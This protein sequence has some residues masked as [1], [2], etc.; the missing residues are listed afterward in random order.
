MRTPSLLVLALAVGCSG[1]YSTWDLAPK[2]VDK[3]QSFRAPEKIA[4]T[5]KDGESVTFDQ[6]TQLVTEDGNGYRFASIDHADGHGEL[7]GETPEGN[8][9]DLDLSASA[10]VRAKHFS[11]GHTVVASVAVSVGLAAVAGIVVGVVGF[12][13]SM[14]AMSEFSGGFGG[15]FGAFG[16]G[17]IIGGPMRDPTRSLRSR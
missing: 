10:G 15:G 8:H 11:V 5:T 16:C 12:E 4:L 9:I 1:C 17:A 6:D 3:L 13:K 2:E 7:S 14:S